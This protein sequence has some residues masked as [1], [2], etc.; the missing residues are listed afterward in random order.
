MMNKTG[1]AKMKDVA[2]RAGVSLMTVSLALRDDQSVNR[3]SPAT[4]ERIL[5][6]AREL[7]YSPNAGARAMRSGVTNTIALYGGYGFVNVRLPFFTEIVSG[8]QDGCE[9]FG[10]DLLL[11]G[12]FR[13]RSADA[14][15]N[16]LRDGRIDGLIVNM[17]SSDPLAQLLRDTHLPVVA[18]ADALPQIPSVVVDDAEGS[19]LIAE[20]L[21]QRDYKRCLYV[22]GGVKAASSAGRRQGFLDHAA[23]LR[24]DVEEIHLSSTPHSG[25]SLMKNWLETNKFRRAQAIVCWNDTSA[26]DLLAQCR[27]YNINVPGDVAIIGFDGCPTPYA[28]F[29]L[30]STV[31]APWAT[32]AQTAVEILN[33]MLSGQSVPEVTTLPVEFIP[34]QTS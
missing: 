25:D 10:K 31:R 20:H 27:H 7:S 5:Q 21:S 17:A 19:R 11:H 18:I 30:L 24:L 13:N 14:I 12:T 28:Q 26:Y 2:E 34:G 22:N 23:K 6:A 3:M 4:R 29:W 1:P 15:Y 9:Q 33:T 8:L 16:E 32:A